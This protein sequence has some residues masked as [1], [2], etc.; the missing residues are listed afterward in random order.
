MVSPQYFHKVLPGRKNRIRAHQG[1]HI[2]PCHK[3]TPDL[4]MPEESESTVFII[5]TDAKGPQQGKD[6]L[7]DFIC[8]LIFNHA[9]RRLYDTVR[10]LFIPAQNRPALPVKPES[11]VHLAPVM[12]GIVHPHDRMKLRS[13]SSEQF[14]QLPVLLTKL[15]LIL[16]SLKITA[17]AS[18]RRRTGLLLFFSLEGILLLF[19]PDR[20]LLLFIP[21]RFL[22]LLTSEE[23]L[24]RSTRG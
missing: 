4:N 5:D 9:G 6:R 23:F 10:I 13:Q 11:G 22:L 15:R 17:A 21:E 16:N 2:L 1:D 24:Y 3:S 14:F 18:G 7:R 19:I 12:S 20:F 8:F